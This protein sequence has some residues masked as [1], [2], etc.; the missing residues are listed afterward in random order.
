MSLLTS[1]IVVFLLWGIFFAQYLLS[2]GVTFARS[3]DE[4]NQTFPAFIE[5]GELI[6][7]GIIDGVDVFT[8][9]GS[10]TIH[11][12]GMEWYFPYRFFAYLGK[13]SNP[14]FMYILFFIFH[15][16]LNVYFTQRLCYICFKMRP[17]LALLI[18]LCNLTMGLGGVN[19][20][21]FYVIGSLVTPLI[22]GIICMIKS[23]SKVFC[24]FSSLFY[25]MAITSGYVNISCVLALI[26][27]LFS[28]VYAIAYN[29]SD[30][31][32]IIYR[33]LISAILGLGICMP[34]L[35]TMLLSNVNADV[36]NMT[37]LSMA[38]AL[39]SES[40]VVFPRLFFFSDKAL[41]FEMVL[42][43]GTIW[44]FLVI[45]FVITKVTTKMKKSEKIIFWI[46]LVGIVLFFLI[47]IGSVLP[48]EKWFY[49]IPVFGGMHDRNRYFLIFAPLLFISFGIALQNLGGKYKKKIIIQ[50]GI[51][52]VLL[53]V[54]MYILAE[55]YIDKNALV[56][57]LTLTGVALYLGIANGFLSKRFL[58]IFSCIMLCY[59]ANILYDRE[60]VTLSNNIIKERN[61]AF[62]TEKRS[63]LDG[64]INKLS[65]KEIYKYIALEGDGSNIPSYIPGNYGWYHRQKFL[66]S[67]YLKYPLH[68]IA[69]SDEYRAVFGAGWYDAINVSYL[70]D[71]RADFAILTQEAI[72]KNPDRYNLAS[73][74]ERVYLNDTMFCAKLEKYVPR[75]YTKGAELVLD[76]NDSLDNGYFY[77]PTLTNSNIENFETDNRT[78]FNIAVNVKTDSE[79]QYSLFPCENYSFYIDGKKYEPVI[80][81]GLAYFQ[82]TPG[83]HN[84]EIVYKDM[85]Q[86]IVFWV[87]SIYYILVLLMG[88]YC[89]FCYCVK[90]KIA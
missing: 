63:L 50:V 58:L 35:F 32:H 47:D 36:K 65:N 34:Y 51:I 72:D 64:F 27:F 74:M 39:S 59:S 4:A 12:N 44:A 52:Y 3:G 42:W 85:K 90:K 18:A 78:Y 70:R 60:E 79:L 33:S 21:A 66:L 56:I 14:L 29:I 73:D 54:A 15:T 46:G 81:Y 10:N 48:L 22:Y 17:A 11:L 76:K 40:S 13:L 61:I 23:N 43:I 6:A 20:A 45:L 49:M 5:M 28:L 67:N 87:F 37:S 19:F 7:E 16:F 41:S 82:L 53:M 31:K 86:V 71:T 89:V 9:N 84:I 1:A 25:A 24:V 26:I 55:Q 77:C 80:D 88:I 38:V 69:V 30:T 2:D 57:E 62:N 75:H 68:S 83:Q 8:V